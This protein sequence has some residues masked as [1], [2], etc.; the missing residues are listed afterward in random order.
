M[1][2]NPSPA[3]DPVAAVEGPFRLKLYVNGA[4]DLSRHAI[5]EA[6]SFCDRLPGGYELL[7]LELETHVSDAHADGVRA[8]P[9][10][11]VIEPE[12]VRRYVGDLS[13]TDRVAE[14]LGLTPAAPQRPSGSGE[15]TG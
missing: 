6:K 11:I 7:V 12:P 5:A 1:N 10:L 3:A 15:Q 4:S 8:T 9:A 14:A 13:A 2:R